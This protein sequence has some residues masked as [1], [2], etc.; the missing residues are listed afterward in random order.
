LVIQGT[1]SEILP[2]HLRF[3]D[4]AL[5]FC[6]QTDDYPEDAK[7]RWT[8]ESAW[9]VDQYLRRRPEKQINRLLNRIREGR[10]EVTAMPFN[11]SE[12]ADEPALK[13]ML[14]PVRHF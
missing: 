4:Y 3:I 5:D 9:A 12:I 6:D 14:H 2:E 13:N 11:L 10:I 1:Q 8:C 7:F